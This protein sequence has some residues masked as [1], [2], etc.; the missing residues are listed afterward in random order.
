M[1]QRLDDLYHKFCE[2]AEYQEF[3][4]S[5]E[6]NHKLLSS[7]LSKENIKCVLRI[8]DALEMI[9]NY[10]SKDSF[11]QGF[12]LGLELTYELQNYEP[13]NCENKTH[14]FG[15]FFMPKEVLKDETEN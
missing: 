6:E 12:K 5:A 11:L 9:C 2:R 15:D 10:E 8:M 4:N 13:R 3:K 1:P 14:S 7:R